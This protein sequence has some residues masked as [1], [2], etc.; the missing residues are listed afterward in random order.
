MTK[1]G[2]DLDRTRE[3]MRKHKLDA[4]LSINEDNI[5]WASGK[6]PKPQ[7]EGDKP[8]YVLIPADPN[9]EPAW[10]LSEYDAIIAKVKGLPITDM[11]IY[12]A[13]QEIKNVDEV[14]HGTA[15][16][17]WK[18]CQHDH[19]TSQRLITE[20][21]KDKGL[22]KA[23]IGIEAGFMANH[24]TYSMI[25]ENN[26][27]VTLVDAEKIFWELRSIKTEDEINAIRASTALALKGFWGML[28]GGVIGKTLIDLQRRFR[29]TVFREL[30]VEQTLALEWRNQNISA[31]DPIASRFT[32]TH[33]IKEGETI[34]WDGGVVLNNYNSDFGR[35]FSAGKTGAL[36]TKLY[37]AMR[38]GF[39][40]ARALI[41]P[42]TRMQELWKA[43][44]EGA[45]KYGI[46]WFFRGHC[47]HTI[48]MGF[49]GEQPP[50]VCEFDET[51]LQ[52]N[53]VIC[54]ESPLFVIGL[55]SF[56]ME[57]EYLITPDGF[58]LLT[59]VT[60]ELVE[61]Y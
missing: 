17:V 34:F 36:E 58:E 1:V 38:A 22:Q 59:P 6:P 40:E 37:N 49:P 11:R 61:L 15:K 9:L 47:G 20:M 19:K 50:F 12:I 7:P 42:G 4:L 14:I 32:P 30:P 54:L 43:V 56:H 57:D 28:S 24:A 5:F 52:P 21:L 8:T 25:K 51:V 13:W 45:R 3:A 18:P 23:T 48:G 60:R 2:M 27:D 46:D 10:V 33:V 26:P 39:E 44:N 29:D 16:R 41:K 55:G 53:M 31:G 35:V